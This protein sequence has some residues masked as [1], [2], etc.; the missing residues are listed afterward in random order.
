MLINV[1][2]P[3]VKLFQMAVLLFE[4]FEALQLTFLPSVCIDQKKP[5]DGRLFKRLSD[6]HD[7]LLSERE[8]AV[9]ASCCGT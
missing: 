8:H 4:K 6:W 1:D 9:C 2:C 5:V 7:Y 3:S